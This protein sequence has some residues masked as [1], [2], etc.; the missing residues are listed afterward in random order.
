LDPAENPKS[1]DIEFLGFGLNCEIAM[2]KNPSPPF[3]IIVNCTFT[4]NKVGVTGLVK[5]TIIGKTSKK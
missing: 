4:I 2:V 5:S 3:K 1:T